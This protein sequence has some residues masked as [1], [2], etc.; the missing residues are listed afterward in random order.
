MWAQLVKVSKISFSRTLILFFLSL[1][2]SC[3]RLWHVVSKEG[4]AIGAEARRGA[5]SGHAADDGEAHG[6]VAGG[7]GEA[8]DAGEGGRGRRS[9][10]C[11]WQ[12]RLI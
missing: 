12:N 3:R 8:R 2:P 7:G 6:G 5:R 1:G 4:R 10:A 9:G 11:L